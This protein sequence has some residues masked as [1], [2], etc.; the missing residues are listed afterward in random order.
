[1]TS[2]RSRFSSVRAFSPTTLNVARMPS[3]REE[4]GDVQ[5]GV[6]AGRQEVVL[7]VEPED[8]VDARLV[9]AGGAGQ[10]SGQEQQGDEERAEAREDGHGKPP[11]NG[12]G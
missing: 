12:R 2:L 9:G 11:E 5:G 3:L 8:D 6:V 7:G 10:G 1:M 4:V